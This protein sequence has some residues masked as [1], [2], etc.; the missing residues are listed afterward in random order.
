[1]A[2]NARN[3]SRFN[4]VSKEEEDMVMNLP[5]KLSRNDNGIESSSDSDEDTGRK[6]ERNLVQDLKRKSNHNKFQLKE[7]NDDLVLQ[8]Y[9]DMLKSAEGS[10]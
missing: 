7:I 1:M 10:L 4:E 3:V 8:K 9:E 2:R 6:K 5:S